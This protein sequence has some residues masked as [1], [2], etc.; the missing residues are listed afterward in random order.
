MVAPSLATRALWKVK[1]RNHDSRHK[2]LSGL[3]S[4]RDGINGAERAWVRPDLSYRQRQADRILHD[5]L[6]RRRDAGER[7]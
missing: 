7:C 6:K 4:V 1:F 5:E 3:R 2:F